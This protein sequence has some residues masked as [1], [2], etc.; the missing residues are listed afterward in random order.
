MVRFFVAR[1]KLRMQEHLFYILRF[2]CLCLTAS[3]PELPGVRYPGGDCGDP[4]SRLFDVIM[5]SQSYL[6]NVPDAV[7][8]CT[9]DGSLGT[10][11][12]L[13]S[14]FSSGNVASD[15]WSHVDN[16][17]KADFLKDLTSVYRTLDVKRSKDVRTDNTSTSSAEGKQKNLP[18]KGKKD[19]FG[20]NE[21]PEVKKSIMDLTPGPSK[22]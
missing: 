3:S 22:L 4:R 14:K 18:R 8:I 17:G 1:P 11:R 7:S 9:R 6:F 21:T 19:A 13:E 5:P 2:S 16:F 20:W 12:N 15:P 10:Y